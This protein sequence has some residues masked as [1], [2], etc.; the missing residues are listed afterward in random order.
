MRY[1]H[2]HGGG[3]LR[4]A[5][6][7]L[8]ATTVVAGVAPAQNEAAEPG[9][10]VREIAVRKNR[11]DEVFH[12][13]GTSVSFWVN[14]EAGEFTWILPGDTEVTRFADSEGIDLIAGH[15]RR[16][17]AWEEKVDRLRDEGRFVSMGRTRALYRAER[18]DAEEGVSGFYLVIESWE[19]PSPQARSLR[20]TAEISYNVS[21]D[22]IVH[23]E[24]EEIDLHDTKIIRWDDYG[25]R[26]T[27]F[28]RSEGTL[29][30][31]LVSE[32]ELRRF[33]VRNADGEVVGGI[34]YR[35]NN[36]P[37]VEMPE[38]LF[39]EPVHLRIE[40]RVPV[41]RRVVIDEVIDVGL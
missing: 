40:Y 16:I 19:V 18:L 31:T 24:F 33:D 38:D 20:V 2:R 14:D 39:E 6:L 30:F 10:E 1:T 36:R 32:L 37:V 34:A 4:R 17:R 3:R 25:V 12:D 35:F 26:P 21:T 28:N 41:R 7:A 22:K 11:P 8:V 27:D 5:A 15:E 23:E 29:S 13:A 9:I